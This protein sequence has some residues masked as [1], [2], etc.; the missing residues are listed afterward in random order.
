MSHTVGLCAR[1]TGR[2]VVVYAIIMMKDIIVL[3]NSMW[4]TV[5]APNAECIVMWTDGP[6]CMFVRKVEDELA[7]ANTV[8]S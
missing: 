8:N 2:V 7:E 3:F 4:G 1:I 5:G 6:S